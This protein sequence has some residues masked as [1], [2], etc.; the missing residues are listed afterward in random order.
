[1]KF[2]VG[3][4]KSTIKFPLFSW[5]IQLFEWSKFSH[6]YIEFRLDCVDR[7]LIFQS[8]KGMVNIMDKDVFLQENEIVSEFEIDVPLNVYEDM[9]NELTSNAGVKYASKQNVGIVLVRIA[10]LFGKTMKNPWRC[11]YNCSELVFT[12][13]IKHIYPTE[14]R[15]PDL[16]TPKEVHNILKTHKINN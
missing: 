5:L 8:S 12:H 15:D 13:V 1:M 16:V 11:G 7:T 10:N 2:K 9:I 3:F 14:T 4:S 6:T